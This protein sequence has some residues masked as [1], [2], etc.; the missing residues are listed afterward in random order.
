MQ[1]WLRFAPERLQA[2]EEAAKERGT[3]D[4][5][6]FLLTL[7]DAYYEL[8]SPI[9]GEQQAAAEQG[10]FAAVGAMRADR[11]EQRNRLAWLSALLQT[12]S[13]LHEVESTAA[14]DRSADMD[15][16]D[17]PTDDTAE[18]R[19]SYVAAFLAAKPKVQW[20]F[21]L[22]NSGGPPVPGLKPTTEL[23][24]EVAVDVVRHKVIV[25]R[26]ASISI[27]TPLSLTWVWR[28]CR[29]ARIFVGRCWRYR[30]SPT[31]PPALCPH[32]P[33]TS[34]HPESVSADGRVV[35]VH[36][37]GAAHGLR[38]Q[39]HALSLEAVLAK[40]PQIGG[41]GELQYHEVADGLCVPCRP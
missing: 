22:Q 40:C 20:L 32:H 1:H 34:C 10:G 12:L 26:H 24:A 11:E 19:A 30:S 38:Q 41:K 35:V 37:S 21:A 6:A 9:H 14:L 15:V 17:A 4:H 27:T 18:F 39:T 25:T 28:A 8:A 16:T 13:R 33:L 23:V 31:P 2:D 5:R 29:R 3:D 36:R 7:C